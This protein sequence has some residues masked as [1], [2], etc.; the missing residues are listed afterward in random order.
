MEAEERIARTLYMSHES[1]RGKGCQKSAGTADAVLYCRRLNEIFFVH[2]AV[3]N[4]Q[5]V[6]RK[7]RLAYVVKH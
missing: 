2:V 6:C 1:A 4:I 3:R 7:S 5:E